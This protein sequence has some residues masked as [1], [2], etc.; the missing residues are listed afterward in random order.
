MFYKHSSF[1]CLQPSCG[2]VM[3]LHMSVTLSTGGVWCLADNPWADTPT[4][5][6]HPHPGQTPP[7]G[8][9]SPGQTYP[10][11]DTPSG[12]TLPLGRCPPL[13]KHPLWA[14]TPRQTPTPSD[15]H[16]SGQYA[17]YLNAFL[18]SL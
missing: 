4:L 6:Q 18:F 1:Y 17:S 16:C 8:R 2:K 10:W 9:H 3:F 11:A 13:G 14:D 5:G 7:L 15:G 12:Q